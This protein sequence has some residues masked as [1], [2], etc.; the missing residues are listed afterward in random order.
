MRTL[1][2]AALAIASAAPAAAAQWLSSVVASGLDN[3]RG[4][5]FGPDGAL[6]V[7]EGGRYVPGG[8]STVVRGAT[9]TYSNSAAITR[10]HNGVQQRI[11]SGLPSIGSA[12]VNETTGPNDIAFAPDGTGYVLFGLGLDPTARTTNLAP[13]G[14]RL[15][16][17]Y[18]F[19]GAGTLTPIADI[20]AFEGANN[21]AGGPVDSNPYR[22]V[23][24]G[25]GEAL[26][27][28]A[29]ANALLRVGATGT[30]SL[31]A[32]FP[33]RFIGGPPPVSDSVTT[34]IAIGPDGNYYVAELTG[35]PFTAG[36][37]RIYRVS[38]TGIVEIAYDGFTMISD[39]AFGAD[40]SLFV[41]EVDNNG[42]P[43]PGG[44]GALTRIAPDGT[45]QTIFTQGLVLP[46]AL[47]I[48]PDQ[49]LYVTNFSAAE[50]RGEVLRVALVPEPSSWAM[51][52][53]G[54]GLAGGAL[55]TARRR[56]IGTFSAPL[57][58]ARS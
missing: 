45:R 8:P 42:L 1:I 4:L 16:Q 23:A 39:L 49:A 11:A 19:D 46:T 14:F 50:G 15:G 41:L 21:P 44:S 40:G 54:M 57:A 7:A 10:V 3:P 43:T 26:V 47:A 24:L 33:G 31:L 52:I 55:R 9:F 36:A 28:D 35:F 56:G 12:T 29:G 13:D 18:S 5:A 22:M 58:R 34:G 37:A 48:G 25:G 38:P 6:Y 20:A 2:V 17:L 27:T 30:V 32:T 51:L 53:L